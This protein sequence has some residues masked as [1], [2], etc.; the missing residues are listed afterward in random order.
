MYRAAARLF[1][2]SCLALSGAAFA[3]SPGW[4][5]DGLDSGSFA[6][7]AGETSYGWV[8]SIESV[9]E[10]DQARGTGALIGGMIGAVIG[11]QMADS[12]HGRNIATA[13][14]AAAGALIGHEIDKGSRRDRASVRI[15]VTLDGGGT[16]SFE[17]KDAGG[18]RVGDRVR[19]EG[20]QLFRAS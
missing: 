20:N 8:R 14:G 18:L 16:R 4:A 17:W 13:I 1:I 12:S 5:A 10:A 15:T 9:S 7:A 2:A 6:T 19:V 11:R 3:Q